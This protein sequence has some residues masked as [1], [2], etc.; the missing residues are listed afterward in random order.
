M[1]THELMHPPPSRSVHWVS[2]WEKEGLLVYFACAFRSAKQR[3]LLCTFHNTL[4]AQM[5]NNTNST[6]AKATTTAIVITTNTT[7]DKMRMQ[8]TKQQWQQCLTN[9]TVSEE[10]YRETE[11]EWEKWGQV[12]DVS[13]KDKDNNNNGSNNKGIDFTF[14]PLCR[15]TSVAAIA[16]AVFLPHIHMWHAL[17]AAAARATLTRARGGGGDDVPCPCVWQIVTA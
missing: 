11:K 14:P 16:T 10:R 17:V 7:N 2:E 12:S 3:K 13:S 6:A 4:Q 5:R 1:H 15:L 8:D 9:F